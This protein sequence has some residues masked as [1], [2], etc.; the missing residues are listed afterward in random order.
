MPFPPTCGNT[1]F[2]F[3]ELYEVLR[4]VKCF[5]GSG[6]SLP[7]AASMPTIYGVLQ[8]SSALAFSKEKRTIDRTCVSELR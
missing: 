4:K 8:G 6:S 5:A 3:S 7:L 1:I 2:A